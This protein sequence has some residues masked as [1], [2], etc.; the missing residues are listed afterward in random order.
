M[1]FRCRAPETEGEGGNCSHCSRVV[2]QQER[3]QTL[4]PPQE[5]SPYGGFRCAR[6]ADLC[7]LCC[8]IH[9]SLT[10]NG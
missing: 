4:R 8:A 10:F 9:S 2:L 1:A 5:V 7:W 3:L 6:V